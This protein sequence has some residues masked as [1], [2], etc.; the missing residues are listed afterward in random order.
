MSLRNMELLEGVTKD[1]LRRLDGLALDPNFE[2]SPAVKKVI[3]KADLECSRR[4]G[5]RSG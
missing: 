3:L 5:E 1:E 2:A 4:Q